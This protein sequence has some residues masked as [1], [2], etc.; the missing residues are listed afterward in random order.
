MSSFGI[1]GVAGPTSQRLVKAG[2]R[3]IALAH[4]DQTKAEI[5][6]L[7]I[8]T[9]STY[10]GLLDKLEHPR[11]H[12]LE[13]AAGSA[14][15]Q[16][17]DEASKTMEPADMVIDATSSYWCDTLRRY[18]RMRH[19]ALYYIDFA[20]IERASQEHLII[21]GD[22]AAIDQARPF[23]ANLDAQFLHLGA[24]SSAHYAAVVEECLIKAHQ[25]VRGEAALMM[26]AF[27]AM[28]D[29]QIVKQLWP[30]VDRPELGRAAWQLDDAT[31]LE[32]A[33]PLLAQSAMAA[34]ADALEE[35]RSTRPPPRVGPYQH[36]DDII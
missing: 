13:M 36:P 32:A 31:Q 18:R 34:I 24:P 23:L 7:G 16:V 10:E 35:H 3:A 22:A 28:V 21:G 27:P 20:W 33:T 4:D 30:L 17:I 6:S 15:D 8:E 11:I 29:D 25:Q 26:E 14:I 19:R 5:E 12:L 1:I 9:V 2:L